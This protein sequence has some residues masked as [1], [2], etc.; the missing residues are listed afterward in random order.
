LW[1]SWFGYAVRIAISFF[2][3]PYITSVLGDARYG[4]WVIVF[5]TINYF[6]LLD[7][8]LEKALLR[9]VSKYLGRSDYGAINRVLN[10]TFNLYLIVG[11]I[12]IAGAW[13]VSTFL[14]DYFRIAD[15]SM[16]AEGKSALI[17]IGFYMGFRFYLL[18]FAGSLGGFQRFDISN[19][20]H[21]AEDLIRA[22]VMVWLLAEG[23]G[24]VPL[25]LAI[26]GMS[27]VR[28]VAAIIWLKKLHPQVS[29]AP[30][31][32]DRKVSRELLDYSKVTFG[33]TLAWLVI[34][35]TD[36]VLLG[37]MASSSAA[38]IYAPGAQLMLYLRN[39]VNVVASPLTA[40]LSHLDAQGKQEKIRAWYLKGIRYTSY[41]SFLM[42]VGVIAYARPFVTLWLEPEFAE[43]AEVMRILAVSAAFFIPQ[44]VGNAVL[45][46]I[47]RHAL[48]LRVLVLEV[49]LKL[50]LSLSLIPS[51]G[52]IGMAYASAVPQLLLYL[53]I[54][55][56]LIGKTL[57]LPVG[58][59]LLTSV[60]SGFVAM[61]VSLP[62]IVLVRELVPPLGWGE[63][64]VNVGAVLLVATVAAWFVL[65]PEDKERVKRRLR[66]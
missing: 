24:L 2:F 53:T 58:T 17:I 40:A 21:M 48:M 39:A 12:I 44:I 4:V 3:V 56:W 8:G 25:A 54:Y 46:A 5:Q 6:V 20:L 27:L 38:G 45:F 65:A 52:L 55:P 26:L 35:N 49:A 7:F 30:S 18:P 19:G 29:M 60:R 22:G 14:F 41:L 42:A 62:V 36:A 15:P 1:T 11:S 64:F 57:E 63:F 33:I 50:V 10:T 32:R 28:Q 34:F 47:D 51:H 37:L 13:L 61:F 43:A 23:Y 59:I 16:L 31:L 9:F 66:R